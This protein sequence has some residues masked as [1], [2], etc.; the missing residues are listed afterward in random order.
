MVYSDVIKAGM[1]LPKKPR[2]TIRDYSKLRKQGFSIAAA[3]F[4]VLCSA[5]YHETSYS[6]SL[7][8]LEKLQ[9]KEYTGGPLC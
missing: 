6:K 3:R 8:S 5:V 2:Y 4:I 7:D 9:I 1:I